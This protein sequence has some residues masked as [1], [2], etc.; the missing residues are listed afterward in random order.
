MEKVDWT[1]EIMRCLKFIISQFKKGIPINDAV[2]Q[3]YSSYPWYI[4]AEAVKAIHRN[5]LVRE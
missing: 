4:A 3:A 5:L 2:T 1:S